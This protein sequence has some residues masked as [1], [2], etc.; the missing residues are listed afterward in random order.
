M[1]PGFRFLFAAIALS[2]S[3][4]IFGLGAAALLRAA[5]EEF[6]SNSSWRAAPEPPMLAKTDAPQQVLAMLQVQPQR[7]GTPM[8]TDAPPVGAM[9]PTPVSPALSVPAEPEAVIP[10]AP[11][12]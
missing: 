7:E 10:T 3:V 11:G 1:L 9:A 8:A 12:T 2:V 5:H 4:L 6:A